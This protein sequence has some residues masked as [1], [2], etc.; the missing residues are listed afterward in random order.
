MTVPAPAP[1]RISLFWSVNSEPD[2]AGYILYRSTD[3]NLPKDNWTVITPAGFT[4]TTFTD[5]NVETGKTYYY[6]VKAVDNA[7][8]KSDASQVVSETVP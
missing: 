7:G 2:L 6:Y 5:T 8:N 4:R 1:G 3:P